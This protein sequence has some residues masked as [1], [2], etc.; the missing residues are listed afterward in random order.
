MKKHLP[1]TILFFLIA[2]AVPKPASASILFELFR[3]VQLFK[4]LNI[5]YV[6]P[7]S[8]YAGCG[9]SCTFG[10]LTYGTVTA[11]SQ[12]WLDRNLGASSYPYVPTGY[13]DSNAY[14]YY[15]QWGR[16]SD[17]HQISTS[18][19][20]ASLSPS[21]VP[22]HADFINVTGGSPW[23]WRDP[24]NNNLSTIWGGVNGTSSPCPAGWR[25]PTQAEWQDVHT[26]LSITNSSTAFSSMLKLP[27]AGVR[28]YSDGNVFDMNG[29]NFWSSTVYNSYQ[30]M[31]YSFSNIGAG[32]AIEIRSYG[33]SVRCLKN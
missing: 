7:C 21:D 3:N 4:S 28:M 14:G 19:T 32:M 1:I 11:N 12:C 15:F 23:D 5:M 30:V 8:S 18:G 13:N 25:L 20:R 26:A 10:G 2:L 6:P 31:K 29:G 33:E 16:L 27:S 9:E 24:G 22:G 17:G